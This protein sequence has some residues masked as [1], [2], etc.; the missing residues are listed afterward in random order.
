M[1]AVALGFGDHPRRTGGTGMSDRWGHGSGLLPGIGSGWR[2]RLLITRQRR[3]LVGL[4][5][6]Q[7]RI[8]LIR[9]FLFQTAII[10][11]DGRL[12]VAAQRGKSRSG[13]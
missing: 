5:V 11:A 9:G 10:I 13:T 3:A 4:V 8:D 12:L 1:Q 6:E 7:D 2:R